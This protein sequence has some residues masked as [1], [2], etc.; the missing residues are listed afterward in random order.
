[1]TFSSINGT[2]NRRGARYN[3]RPGE[4]AALSLK[5]RRAGRIVRPALLH[6]P[7]IVAAM[8]RIAR[9][10]AAFCSF[11]ST[12]PAVCGS[13]FFGPY[14]CASIHWRISAFGNRT[15]LWIFTYGIR[16]SRT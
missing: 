11:G 4:T 7:L 12:G 14:L 5:T 15:F 6:P 3:G 8:R 10:Y 1:D 2:L 13:V 9:L 16:P